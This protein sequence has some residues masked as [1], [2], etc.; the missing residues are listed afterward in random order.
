MKVG[1]SIGS[2]MA[3]D[4]FRRSLEKVMTTFPKIKFVQKHHVTFSCSSHFKDPFHLYF[5]WFLGDI[6]HW[7]ISLFGNKPRIED[8]A[9]YSEDCSVKFFLCF[10]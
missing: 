9:Y 2:Y 7:T 5:C 6:L 3:I 4:I 8:A 10:E 1:H